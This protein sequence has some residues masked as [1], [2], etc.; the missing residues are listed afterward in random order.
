MTAKFKTFTTEEAKI[1]GDQIGIDWAKYDIEQ[2]RRGLTVELEHGMHDMQTDVSDDGEVITGKIAL[3]HL[4]EIP[5]YYTR[6][7]AME[8]EYERE[9]R[10]KASV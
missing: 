10:E 9:Q 6:L 3:A 2:F 7:E 5:D 8:E 4:K 1:I